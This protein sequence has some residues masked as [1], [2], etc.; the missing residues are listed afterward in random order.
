MASSRDRYYAKMYKTLTDYNDSKN[1]PFFHEKILEAICKVIEEEAI[2]NANKKLWIHS[3]I[4][5]IH[6]EIMQT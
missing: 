4:L 3:V 1:T 2:A 5:P 6:K